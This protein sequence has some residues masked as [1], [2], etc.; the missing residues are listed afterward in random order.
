MAKMPVFASLLIVS[1]CYQ[2]P[3]HCPAN[4]IEMFE[5]LDFKHFRFVEYCLPVVQL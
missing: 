3:G 4:T 1:C 2:I 5:Q